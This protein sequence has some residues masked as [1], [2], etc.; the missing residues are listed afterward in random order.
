MKWPCSGSSKSTMYASSLEW[1]HSWWFHSWSSVHNT[2]PVWADPSSCNTCLLIILPNLF[3][4]PNF[5]PGLH[6]D[7]PQTP[8]TNVFK[9]GL[10]NSPNPAPPSTGYRY[11]SVNSRT[12]PESQAQSLG[13]SLDIYSYSSIHTA[14]VTISQRFKFTVSSIYLHLSN[15]PDCV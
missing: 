11:Q 14:S 7:V 13:V 4:S 2:R 10:I 15:P 5:F 6:Y 12:K 9:T 3:L 8:K 1:R